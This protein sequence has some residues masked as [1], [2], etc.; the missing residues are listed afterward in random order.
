MKM[1]K[2]DHKTESVE[3]TFSSVL[4]RLLEGGVKVSNSEIAALSHASSGDAAL[5]EQY[6]V[7]IVEE[8]KAHILGR[9]LELADDDPTL[10]FSPLYR[11]MVSD[12]LAAVRS[13][14]V[15]G[16]W[17]AEDP[18]LIR[19]MIPIMETDPAEEVRAAA[20]ETLGNFTLLA[21]HG[22][23][24]REIRS[25]LLEKLLGVYR[26]AGESAEVRRRA[27]ESLSYISEPEVAEA[28]TG[29]YD[30]DDLDWRS[31]A[32]CAAG[33]NL[34][35]R[36]LD[37]LLDELFSDIPEVRFQAIIACGEYEDELAVPQLISLTQDADTQ[38][39]LAAITV[40]GKIGGAEATRH[41]RELTE[42]TD[43]A[44]AELAGTVLEDMVSDDEIMEML[45][46]DADARGLK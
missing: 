27:L 23:L 34:D 33:R 38:I 4:D 37:M 15:K 1:E 46:N 16:L 45:A 30:S 41:L 10:D 22:K 3:L 13:G 39:K 24:S 9:M 35:P 42:G 21:E 2:P 19:L 7:D 20:A 17:E 12:N 18:S 32:L 11:R 29:S 8:R 40:L 26:D 6:W 31:S 14:A 28:I 43:E 36:W 5:F 44:E 25:L